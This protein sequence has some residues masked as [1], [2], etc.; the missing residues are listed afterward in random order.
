MPEPNYDLHK[1]GRR[2]FQDLCGVVL[3]E[4]LGQTFTVFADTND[5][6]QDGAFHC[7][8]AGSGDAPAPE[9]GASHPVL[10][11]LS[12]SASSVPPRPG[13]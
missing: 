11:P 10:C 5:A 9:L 8:W 6:G 3:Q 2:A 1:L 12:R 4:V 7:I 13:R